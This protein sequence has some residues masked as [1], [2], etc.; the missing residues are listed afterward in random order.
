MREKNNAE[1]K[2][3]QKKTSTVLLEFMRHPKKEKDPNKGPREQLL[4]EEGRQAAFKRGQD[5][6]PEP[7]VS[8]AFGSGQSRTQ[9]TSALTMLANEESLDPSMSLEQMNQKIAEELKVGKKIAVEDERLDF[10]LNGPIGKRGNEMF[11]AGQYLE[12]LINESDKLAKDLGDK[13]STTYLRH[14]GNIAEIIYKYTN[15]GDN[16]NKAVLKNDKYEKFSNQL[17][18]Y[19]GTHN[20]VTEMFVAKII[21]NTKGEEAR[22]KF[23]EK[24]GTGGFKETEGPQVKIVNEGDSQLIKLTYPL[25]NEEVTININKQDLQKIMEQRKEFEDNIK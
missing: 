9:E 13:E 15:I 16:F 21:E 25:E 14:A 7:A 6:N 24:L 17:E 4:T 1:I 2:E 11:K 3:R 19:L 23:L 8:V 18:R 10:N 12:F 20:S 22:N 5:I